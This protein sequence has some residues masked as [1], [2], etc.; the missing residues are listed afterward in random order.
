[1]LRALT[2]LFNLTL[3]VS[4]RQYLAAGSALMLLKYVIDNAIVH[5]FTGRFWSPVDHLVPSLAL[6]TPSGAAPEPGAML[7]ALALM[8]LPFLWV[9]LTMSMRRALDAS[10]S[11]WTA[12]LF[13]V[14]I[15]N[16]FLMAWLCVAPSRRGPT[17]PAVNES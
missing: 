1:M 7:M 2:I 9:G 4:R 16:L 10:Y 8:A 15:I 6:R 17:K 14:P 13:F 12:V 11:P 3:T 5:T